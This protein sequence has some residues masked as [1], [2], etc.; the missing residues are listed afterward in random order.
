MAKS[1]EEIST[2]LGL[3]M[4]QF[5]GF[6]TMMQS[7]MDSLDAMG[8]WQATADAVFD[9]FRERAQGTTTSLEEVNKHMERATS[10]VDSLEARL[11]TP[12]PPIQRAPALRNMD[13]NVAPGS[14]SCSP[15]MDGERAKGHG[16]DCGGLLGPRPQD[17]NKG[18][19]SVPN[20]ETHVSDEIV[21]ATLR[22]PPFPKLDFPKF[23]GEFPRLWRDECEMF[24]EVYAVERS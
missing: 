23:D 11:T 2:Q 12:T 24:F 18:T 22:S 10:R 13:L 4:K 5:V 21:H 8:T 19:H 7:T 20:L 15:A 6:Q 16:E 17:S 14:S 9:E 1:L 3:M